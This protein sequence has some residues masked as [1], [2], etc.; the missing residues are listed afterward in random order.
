MMLCMCDFSVVGSALGSTDRRTIGRNLHLLTRRY[1]EASTVSH[2]RCSML[3]R[4]SQLLSSVLSV[5]DYLKRR[6]PKLPPLQ[7][8]A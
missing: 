2:E 5:S 4:G 1:C 3:G 8:E 6:L 7:R